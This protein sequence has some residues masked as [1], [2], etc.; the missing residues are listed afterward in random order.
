MQR[1]RSGFNSER[2][3]GALSLCLCLPHPLPQ[4]FRC[5]ITTSPNAEV[6]DMFWLTDNRSELPENHR[7]GGRAGSTHPA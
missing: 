1:Q 2:L 3:G 6:L 7:V 5:H 4:V